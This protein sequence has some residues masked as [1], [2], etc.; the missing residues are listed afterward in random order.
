MAKPKV[1][2]EQPEEKKAE[3]PK[4]NHIPCTVARH[5]VDGNLAQ[6][7]SQL[8]YSVEWAKG[9]KRNL[10]MWLIERVAQS[11]GEVELLRG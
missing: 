4:E 11:G 10:P 5:F 9:E 7:F 6:A 2:A 3:A 8:G 1:Q